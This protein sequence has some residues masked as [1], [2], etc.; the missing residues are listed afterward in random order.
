MRNIVKRNGSVVNFDDE[1]IIRA[2]ELAYSDANQEFDEENRKHV[3]DLV[4]RIKSNEQLSTVEAIQDEVEIQ[5]MKFAP[6]V[7]KHYILYRENKQK[8]RSHKVKYEFLRPEFLAEYK[9]KKPALTDIGMFTFIRT[10]SRFIPELGRRENY[11]ETCARAVNANFM[12]LLKYK[13]MLTV[14]EF[15]IAQ[16]E[17]EELFD[18]V[19]NCRQFLSG[20]IFWIGGTKVTDDHPLAAMNCSFTRIETFEDFNEV[21][22]LLML[23]CGV[24]YSID[25]TKPRNLSGLRSVKLT[26]ADYVLEP[27]DRRLEYTQL[28]I[29]DDTAT[30]HVGDSKN[31]WCMALKYYFDLRSNS[32]YRHIKRI[33]VNYDS[34]RPL[35]EPL[36]KFGGT[37][38]GHIA[39]LNMLTKI[40]DIT[41]ELEELTDLSILDICGSI[42]QCIVVG[43]QRRSALICTMN[44]TQTDAQNAKTN[45]YE[46]NADGKWVINSK[47]DQRQM[48]NNSVVYY[49]KPSFEK[50]SEHFD[51]MRYSGEPGLFNMEEMIKRFP[52]AEGTNPCGEIILPNKG[53][54]NLT[55]L[56]VLSFVDK[57]GLLDIE[58]LLKAQKLSARAGL[59]VT[60]NKL[61]IDRWNKTQEKY[62]LLGCS[63]TGWQDMVNAMGIRD[64]ANSQGLT[65]E[66][67]LQLL[68]EAAQTEADRYADELEVNRPYNVT[69]VKPEGTLSLLP[70]VSSG[71]HYSHAPYYIRRIRIMTKDPLCKLAKK[72]GYPMFP[73]VGHSVDNPTLMV[74]EFPVKAPE[75]LT[76]GDVSA[77][78]QL[79]TYLMFQKNYTQHNTSIT[80]H[81]KDDEWEE[82]KKWV[83][84]NWDNGICGLS[85]LS[86]SDSYY[87]LLPYES[88]TKEEYEKRLAKCKPFTINALKELENEP[89]ENTLEE[90]SECSSGACPVR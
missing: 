50:L 4:S 8:E 74:V 38:S 17:A 36:K 21:M 27:K 24:G 7:A 80:V 47:I 86:Y 2:C 55:T 22:Y 15:E 29:S 49:T 84:E 40:H 20:R 88:I 12:F 65:Q 6:K 52:D 51:K 19:F 71:V 68:K 90:D 28:K 56:N 26:H 11:W 83:Y 3:L 70:T 25:N 81:V 18:N 79:E 5:L 66:K 46:L 87:D 30:I 13:N 57:D 43:G 37:A 78:K 16:K 42:A 33:I 44:E 41:N 23:G 69:T 61:E 58:A 67:I 62:R 72:L 53:L 59:R 75:G 76:K 64:G 34:V 73:E 1:R 9:H 39:L 89:Q 60:L 32:F 10:Y 45:L 54:C 48:S 77:L 31:G 85:F 14:K 63:L 82:V 35:G